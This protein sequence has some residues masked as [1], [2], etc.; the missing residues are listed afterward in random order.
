[1]D[2]KLR[3]AK[4][5]IISIVAAYSKAELGVQEGFQA[6]AWE[7]EKGVFAQAKAGQLQNNHKLGT[8]N[9]DLNFEL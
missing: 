5:W 7:P 4:M 1:M 2:A 9:M 6:G 3:L 8:C